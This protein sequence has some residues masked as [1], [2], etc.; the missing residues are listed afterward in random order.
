MLCRTEA[1]FTVVAF[2]ALLPGLLTLA[3]FRLICTCNRPIGCPTRLIPEWSRQ[4]QTPDQI[5][6]R[7]WGKNAKELWWVL[8]NSLGSSTRGAVPVVWRRFAVP[9]IFSIVCVRGS[10]IPSFFVSK[11]VVRNEFDDIPGSLYVGSGKHPKM[12]ILYTAFIKTIPKQGPL[13]I[14]KYRRNKKNV[15][16]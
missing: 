3:H 8:Q 14:V 5:C 4:T 15:D 7:R 12:A 6:E 2:D 13:W 11:E 16:G 9:V 1:P 10:S